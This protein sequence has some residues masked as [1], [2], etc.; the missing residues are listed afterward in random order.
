MPLLYVLKA[1]NKGYYQER[2]QGSQKKMFWEKKIRT[3]RIHDVALF[4]VEA[5]LII[6]NTDL[7]ITNTNCQFAK[8]EHFKSFFLFKNH[9]VT[10]VMFLCASCT[11]ISSSTVLYCLIQVY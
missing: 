6:F 5:F 9:E 10:D 8:C 11:E 4:H 1:H 2:F 3:I 7:K